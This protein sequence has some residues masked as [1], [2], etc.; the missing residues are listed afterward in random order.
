MVLIYDNNKL[1]VPLLV[2]S[3]HCFSL[4]THVSAMSFHAQSS[5]VTDDDKT[6]GSSSR[7]Q[8]GRAKSCQGCKHVGRGL[9]ESPV[10]TSLLGLRGADL[11]STEAGLLRKLP[12]LASSQETHT[13]ADCGC[14]KLAKRGFPLGRLK[15]SFS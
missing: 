10:V 9:L 14:L 1:Y 12:R 8:R 3:D 4:L 11:L 15:I 5:F 2:V 6:Q 13:A 7:P